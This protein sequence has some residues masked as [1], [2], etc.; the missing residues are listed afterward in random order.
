MVTKFALMNLFSNNP[1]DSATFEDLSPYNTR[2]SPKKSTGVRWMSSAS[3]LSSA[4]SSSDCP[5]C[6]NFENCG[7]DPNYNKKSVKKTAAVSLCPPSLREQMLKK[8]EW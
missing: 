3:S 7:G 5:S 6:P 4:V 2:C 8:L 1:E